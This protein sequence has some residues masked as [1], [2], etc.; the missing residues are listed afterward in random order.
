MKK[1]KTMVDELRACGFRVVGGEA[2]EQLPIEANGETIGQVILH[3]VTLMSF[4]APPISLQQPKRQDRQTA[5]K[6]GRRA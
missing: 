5:R 3:T 1:N 4:G 6:I 2:I